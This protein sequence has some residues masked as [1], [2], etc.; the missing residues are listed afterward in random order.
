[1]PD[2]APCPSLRLR[3][4]SL[5]EWR[6]HNP[7]LFR[8]EM[9]HVDSVGKAKIGDGVSRFTE[10]PYVDG[11]YDTDYINRSWW[12]P[13]RSFL[14]DVALPS[15]IGSMIGVIVASFITYYFFGR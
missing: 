15:F 2:K 11:T 3:S 9:V 13:S 14:L 12:K 7:V 1:M 10:L 8:G 4:G 5:T 6:H